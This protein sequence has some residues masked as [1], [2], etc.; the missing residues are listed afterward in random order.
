MKVISRAVLN[1]GIVMQEMKVK[2]LLTYIQ[3]YTNL[4]KCKLNYVETMQ[5]HVAICNMWLYVIYAHAAT[6]KMKMRLLVLIPVE[7]AMVC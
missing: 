6:N 1:V 4:R 5:M 2:W 7:D 3:L